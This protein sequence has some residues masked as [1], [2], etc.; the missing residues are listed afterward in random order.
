MI[1]PSQ[2]L[3]SPHF[4][5]VNPNEIPIYGYATVCQVTKL[6]ANKFPLQKSRQIFI[7]NPS[8]HDPDATVTRRKIYRFSHF[9]WFGL[10]RSNRPR[11]EQIRTFATH[12]TV[13]GPGNLQQ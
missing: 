4:R 7:A 11:R 12:L 5:K 8:R 10:R 9:F 6:V 13:G 1:S 2:R 3:K